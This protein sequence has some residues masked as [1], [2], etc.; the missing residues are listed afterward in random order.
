MIYYVQVYLSAVIHLGLGM[1]EYSG[2][3]YPEIIED[4]T[5]ILLSSFSTSDPCEGEMFYDNS[6]K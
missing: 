2:I 3:L 4:N 6:L 1:D 5:V